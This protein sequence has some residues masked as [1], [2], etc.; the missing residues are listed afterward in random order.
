[1][2]HAEHRQSLFQEHQTAMIWEYHEEITKKKTIKMQIG[3]F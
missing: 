2:Y 3:N 1:M